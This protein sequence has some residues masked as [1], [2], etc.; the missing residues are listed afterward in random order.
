MTEIMISN[1]VMQYINMASKVTK[2]DILD[3]MITDDKLI[4]IVRKG[5]IGVAIGSK[6]KNIE[7]LKILFKKNIKFVE[8]DDDKQKFLL[9][10][11]KPYKVNQI[12]IEGEKDTSV[13][14]LEVDITDKSKIIG[15][16]GKNIEIIR[17]LAKRHHGIRDVQIA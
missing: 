4:F 12:T 11:C 8:F 17:D 15:K 13:A 2:T 5:F 14:K 7:K 6:A 3:C 9:N 16:G 1:E 10:L